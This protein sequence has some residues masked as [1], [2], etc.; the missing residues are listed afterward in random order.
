M[1]KTLN[2]NTNKQIRRMMVVIGFCFFMGY[3]PAQAAAFSPKEVIK[4]TNEARIAE[5]L[6]VVSENELLNQAARKKAED[7]IKNDYF[8]HTSPA[9]LDPWYWLQKVNYPYKYAGEN[10]AINYESVREQQS[11][12]MKSPSHR[13]NILNANFKEIGVAVVEGKIDGE[14]SILTVEVFGATIP[15][16]VVSKPEAVNP[17]PQTKGVEI[18]NAVP[19]KQPELLPI[20]KALPPIQ[21]EIKVD[22]NNFQIIGLIA[23][24]ILYLSV[25]TGPLI[26][27]WMSF[28]KILAGRKK[29]MVIPAS[30]AM[31][32]FQEHT[33]IVKNFHKNL[34]NDYP[35]TFIGINSS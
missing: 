31:V 17:V 15:A 2:K 16:A 7:M 18:E 1:T 4:L 20:T 32:V 24:I 30:R 9:G 28:A 27:I 25:M 11:A 23:M 3:L 19:V 8:A 13:K 34:K 33:A 10:L 26:F 12:W 35:K 22:S 21:N 29:E 5:N 14:K 6:T